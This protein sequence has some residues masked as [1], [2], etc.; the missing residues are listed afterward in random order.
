[1][2]KL[3][4]AEFNFSDE[5]TIYQRSTQT[6][7]TPTVAGGRVDDDD[8]DEHDAAAGGRVDDDDHE[9]SN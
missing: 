8:A 4:R 7:V 9:E 3:E 6:T 1:M 5:E 2:F